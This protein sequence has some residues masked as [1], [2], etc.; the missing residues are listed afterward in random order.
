MHVDR[1][2]RGSLGGCSCPPCSFGAGI[3]RGGG[4]LRLSASLGGEETAVERVFELRDELAGAEGA[5]GAGG[6][7]EAVEVAGQGEVE[8]KQFLPLLGAVTRALVGGVEPG[9]G[10][11]QSAVGAGA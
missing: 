3:L 2:G 10:G 1:S 8:C 11:F 5:A 9:G 6:R 7:A 4:G